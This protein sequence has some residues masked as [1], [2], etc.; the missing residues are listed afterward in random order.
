M[1]KITI[2]KQFLSTTLKIYEDKFGHPPSPEAIKFK[3]VNELNE[4]A[5]NAILNKKAVLEWERR[6]FIKTGSILDETYI[7]EDKTQNTNKE[8]KE[9]FN[10]IYVDSIKTKIKSI[11][12]QTKSISHNQAKSKIFKYKLFK[13]K[14][15]S[16]IFKC[17]DKGIEASKKILFLVYVIPFAGIIFAFTI[18]AIFGWELPLPEKFF[19]IK[20]YFVTCLYGFIGWVCFKL[21][22][23][24]FIDLKNW[25][26]K[27]KEDLEWIMLGLIRLGL[28][29]LGL[30]LLVF[31]IFQV[32]SNST[33]YDELQYE[34]LLYEDKYPI[35]R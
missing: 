31:I 11:P 26:S 22:E 25:V 15:R 8:K 21:L 17:L 34:D 33:Y 6:A 14:F 2:K 10:T 27:N 24:I 19:S 9:K 23:P 16:N 5:K 29:G 13:E 12:D 3:S 35:R 18:L 20:T 4:L 1:S 30:I 32:N 7:H 28:A